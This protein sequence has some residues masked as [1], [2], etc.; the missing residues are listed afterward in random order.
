MVGGVAV[1]LAV[2]GEGEFELKWVMSGKRVEGLIRDCAEA[3]AT[4]RK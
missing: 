3:W 4:R 2:F 1:V